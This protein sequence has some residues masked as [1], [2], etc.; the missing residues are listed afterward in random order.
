[1]TGVG[2]ARFA[3]AVVLGAETS[4][5][6]PRDFYAKL[7]AEHGPVVPVKFPGDVPA[8]LVIG[9]RELH[10]VTSD[11]DVFTRNREIWSQWS[12]LPQDWPLT[13][14]IGAPGVGIGYCGNAA[15]TRHAHIVSSALEQTD[16]LE[17]RAICEQISDRLV[18][19]FCGSGE[20]DAV[21]QFSI[22]LSA[23]AIAW[24]IGLPEEEGKWLADSLQTFVDSTSDNASAI[25]VNRIHARLRTLL[26]EKQAFPGEDMIT[27]MLEHPESCTEDEY[28]MNVFFGIVAGYLATADWLGNSVRLLLTDDRFAVAL[29][30]ARHSISQAMNEVLW[31]DTPWQIMPGRWVVRDTRLGDKMLHAGDMV[32]LGL[33]GAN[34]DP[35]V[36]QHA[37]HGPE[38]AYSGNAAHFSFSHG[39]FRCPYPA[40]QIAEIISRTGIEVLLDRLP[41]LDLAVAP[42]Q[43]RRRPSHFMRGMVSIPVVFTPVPAVG[44]D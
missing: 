28:V 3:D 4:Q 9:Y 23:L 17:L 13:D 15:H 7:R 39:E 44:Q 10:Q 29:G 33:G 43:L 41:D 16:S 38:P 21:T 20:A 6:E 18:D 27:R 8:W 22:P 42:E 5:L 32:L 37:G 14:V 25:A 19:E 40:Q 36:R 26:G 24:V 1:M 34:D 2:A 31:E 11:P 35:H 30:A 12:Q